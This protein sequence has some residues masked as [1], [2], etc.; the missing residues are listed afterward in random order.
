MGFSKSFRKRIGKKR[1]WV[2]EH[3]GK[4]WCDGFLMEVDHI[5]PTSM[6]GK[7]TESNAQILCVFCHLAK[8]EQSGHRRSPNIIRARLARTGGRWRP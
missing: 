6:G 3:C 5:L 2:C 4:R 1:G 8:H 7:D